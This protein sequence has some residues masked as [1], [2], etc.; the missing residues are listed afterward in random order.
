M[1]IT[2]VSKLFQHLFSAVKGIILRKDRNT[3]NKAEYYSGM[4]KINNIRNKLIL[5]F[6]IPIVLIVLLGFLSYNKSKASVEALAESAALDAMKQTSNYMQLLISNIDAVSFQLASNTDLQSL[7]TLTDSG[8]TNSMEYQNLRKNVTKF[9]MSSLVGNK[10]ISNIAVIGDSEKDSFTS[11]SSH[12]KSFSELNMNTLADA[13]P[14]Y[15][16]IKEAG[17]GIVY[18]G[19]HGEI[20]SD[21][22]TGASDTYSFFASRLLKSTNSGD[23]KGVILIDIRLDEI[24]TLIN[25][26]AADNNDEDVGI[27]E[28]NGG[29][30]SVPENNGSSMEVHLITD[31]GRD[32]SNVYSEEQNMLNTN[33]DFV[34][35]GFIQELVSSETQYGSNKVMYK[36]SDYLLTYQKIPE[37]GYMFVGLQPYKEILSSSQEIAKLTLILVIISALIA[38]LIGLYMSSGMSRTIG[39]IIQAAESA[40]SGDLTV[41][42]VSRRRDEL[43]ILTASINKMIKNTRQLIEQTSVI[44]GKVADS[45]VNL[46]TTSQDV[47]AVSREVSRAIQEIALG[48]SSQASDAEQGVYKMSE[49]SSVINSVSVNARDI[50]RLSEE[51]FTRTRDGIVSVRDLDSK[52]EET[53]EIT[54]AILVDIQALDNN[55]KSIGRIV[56]V[57]GRIA[58]QTNLLAL[59][60]A[61]EAAR[62]GE[63]GKGFAVVAD[64][65]RKLAEQSMSAAREIAEIIKNTQR[66]TGQAVKKA[67]SAGEIIQSQDEAVKITMSAFETIAKSMETLA[68]R[69]GLIISG[70][71]DLETCKEQTISAIENISSVSQETAASSQEVTASTEEQLSSIEELSA[72][73]QAL[74]EAAGKLTE[75]ISRFKVK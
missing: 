13:M 51:T 33:K 23:V 65:V 55:S 14:N 45:A 6:S 54:R 24:L 43:G 27:Q 69:V 52:A 8:E 28:K 58:D 7:Y 74:G 37:T 71:E 47:S 56:S 18:L 53:N 50:Q 38:V 11:S 20:D 60:A 62:A 19:A 66:Q 32:I 40:A 35:N 2:G 61:I 42:L 26:I 70:I 68:G 72:H 31:D 3:A 9:L 46:S 21:M 36:N 57:I 39:R 10:F 44:A 17:G 73:A 48:A 29:D 30:G 59:N 1:K 67:V 15:S 25:T 64:E 75:S 5:A 16:R 41:D 49:L 12:L 4:L 22:A 34:S 63:A